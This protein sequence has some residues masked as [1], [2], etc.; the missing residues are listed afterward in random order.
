MNVGAIVD[1][2]TS[3]SKSNEILWEGICLL[4]EQRSTG[5]RAPSGAGNYLFRLRDEHAYVGEAK[6]LGAR[7]RQQ[8]RPGSSMVYKNYLRACQGLGLPPVATIE[9]FELHWVETGLGRK[10]L[11]EFAIVNLPT[12]LNRFQLGKRDR[13]VY[14]AENLWMEV[15]SQ[16]STLLESGEDA[17]LGLDPAK[18]FSATV[19]AKPGIYHVE[20]PSHGLIYIG[21]SSNIHERYTTHSTNTRFSALRRHIGENILGFE[22]QTKNG[23]RMY[24]ADNQDEHVTTFLR[25]C[26]VRVMPVALGRYEL[27]EHLIKKYRPLLNRKDNKDD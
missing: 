20:H 23:K 19:P 1:W 3:Q 6:N 4:R 22:L 11:E 17:L 21:E 27:E 9:E 13:A 8:L 25:N 16:R 24:F 5:Q 12:N 26:M 15:Q 2:K 18:W 7:L 14:T 10:E